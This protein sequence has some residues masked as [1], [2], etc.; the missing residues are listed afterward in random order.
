MMIPAAE[1]I[2]K[3]QYRYATGQI[4]ADAL[5]QEVYKVAHPKEKL[6]WKQIVALMVV[7]F[8]AALANPFSSSSNDR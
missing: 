7:G 8:V 2:Q 5:A 4:S 6:N 1:I 3:H